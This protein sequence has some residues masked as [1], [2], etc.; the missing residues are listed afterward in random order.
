MFFRLGFFG[1]S[2]GEDASLLPLSM[3]CSVVGVLGEG[4]VSISSLDSSPESKV[5]GSSMCAVARCVSTVRERDGVFLL[6]PA[7]APS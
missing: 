3:P 7:P 5:W 2:T 4:K 6:F 1:E